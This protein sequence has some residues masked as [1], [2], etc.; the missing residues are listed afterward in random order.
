MQRPLQRL[1]VAHL[2]DSAMDARDPVWWGNLLLICIES[3]TMVLLVASYF[4]I[5]RNF[6][7]WP[8]PLRNRIPPIYD[9]SPKLLWGTLNMLLLAASCWVMYITDMAARAHD[10]PRVVRLLAAMTFIAIVASGLRF[11]EFRG[12]YFRW[13]DNA[14]GSIVWTIL[15]THLLYL[16]G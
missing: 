13:D 15:G 10:R 1:D 14:Y 7:E 12:V 2:P 6:W 8:P 4:Y 5:R 16:A 9:P 3:T 11:A